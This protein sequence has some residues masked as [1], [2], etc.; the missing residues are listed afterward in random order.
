MNTQQQI[1]QN[2]HSNPADTLRDLASLDAIAQYA[3]N[4][5]AETHPSYFH[6][7]EAALA[8]SIRNYGLNLVK[9]CKNSSLQ[10]LPDEAIKE[11]LEDRMAGVLD[12]ACIL[13]QEFFKSGVQFSALMMI[14]MLF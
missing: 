4:A 5:M 1:K 13:N 14:Q 8:K 3:L 11:I 7:F 12:V 6:E 2:N 9:E 10:D